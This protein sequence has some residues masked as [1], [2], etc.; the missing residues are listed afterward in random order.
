MTH[1]FI[2]DLSDKSLEELQNTITKLTGNLTYMYRMQNHAMIQQ[3]HMV[4]DTYKA[5]VNKRL[6][7]V[8]KRQNLKNKINV[9]SSNDSTNS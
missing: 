5:E 3:L 4:I 8:Y 6:D 9:Q 7:E 1:P 2:N